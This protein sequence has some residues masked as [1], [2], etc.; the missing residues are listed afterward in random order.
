M[1]EREE[2]L[3][4]ETQ[5]TPDQ[6]TPS[7]GGADGSPPTGIV[8][9]RY[10]EDEMKTSYIDY[11]MS[12]II[13]RALPDVRDGL[14][15]VH[16][17]ILY[18]MN[19]LGFTHTKPHK[20]SARIVGDVLGKYHPHGD[21]A[22]YDSMV[23][24]AQYFS[25]RYMFVDGHGN[26]GS[27][28]GDS[29]AAMRYT[30][31]RLSRIAEE[32]LSDLDKETVDFKPNYDESLLEPDVLP[33]RI[34]NLLINGSSGIAVGMAT[35]IPPHRLTEVV[36]G[37]IRLI[38][39]PHLTIEELMEDVQGP[40]FPTG[41][42]IYGVS[43]IRD[44]YHTGRGKV[45]VRA[46]CE[47][48][49]EPRR[50]PA[51]IVTEIPYMV[52]KSRL[53]EKIV[54]LVR[55]KKIPEIADLRDESDRDGMRMVIELK[56]DSIPNVV[57]NKL[58]KHTELE[59]T[60]GII[61]LALVD[62]KPMVLNLKE[63][64][65]YFIDHRRDVV[66]R[67]CKYELRKAEERAHILEG[68]LI[69]L[70]NIDRVIEI[71]RGSKTADEA[72]ESLM[73]EFGLSQIQAK[74]ILE[75]RLQRLVG[76]ERDKIRLEYEELERKIADLKDILATPSR[77]LN[78]IKEELQE[79]AAKYGDERKTAITASSAEF[80]MEDLIANEDVAITVSHSGYIKRQTLATYRAQGR[81]GK[82]MSSTQMR[83]EDFIRDIFVAMTHDYMLFFTDKGK[84]YWLKVYD[85]PDGSRQ[86]KGKAIINLINIEPGERILTM[87]S[88]SGFDQD[89]FLFFVTRKGIV[90]KTS[91]SSYSRPRRDGIKAI[92]IDEDDELVEVKITDGNS[93][94]ILGTSMGKA[95]QFHESCVRP[96]GRVSRGVKG[97]TLKRGDFVVGMEIVKDED[98]KLLVITENGFG[99]RTPIGEYPTHN[100]G[101]Q[102][103]INIKTN[104]RNGRVVAFCEV[105]DE[106]DVMI[107]TVNGIV[108]RMHV[109][110]I[111]V[112]GRNTQGVRIIRVKD[113]DRVVG[114][115]VLERDDEEET[116]SPEAPD[117]DD[118]VEDLTEEDDSADYDDTVDAGESDETDVPDADDDEDDNDGDGE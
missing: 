81:A 41:G 77:V 62:N 97:I 58:Y 55:D 33:A 101:G 16:R 82:G 6:A 104:T 71:I 83:E 117:P 64:L 11:A 91:L 90:K 13:G 73:S 37:A 110:E 108:I 44:A 42:I 95:A 67:R 118:L 49:E 63:I 53:L 38:D 100:R 111:S 26:F 109:D 4:Q 10:I 52:N 75:M 47:I 2:I 89:K 114:A 76:L 22:V 23:R 56:N 78:I 65:R 32:M 54:D 69:A 57:L 40:D 103:V 74:A 29:A 18:T 21:S 105:S 87:K 5:E 96:M 102:G 39:N 7:G 60:F 8:L 31:A 72:S 15:P 50:R 88:V 98:Q 24:M 45:V 99:K 86:S 79:I 51:I 66:R 27:V 14:K 116:V 1:D 25:Q 19:E 107:V 84:V 46:K 80:S 94:V 35:N 34:P 28:D 3:N 115:E 61:M 30:E 36:Q 9:P 85:I 20:K 48:V 112:V 59:S 17:R 113:G 106:Q 92:N 68:L 43:G 93:S 70:D 12:V